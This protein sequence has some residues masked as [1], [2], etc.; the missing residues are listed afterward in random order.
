MANALT[1]LRTKIWAVLDADTE[2]TRLLR[3][4]SKIKWAA[5][6][7]AKLKVEPAM[8]P[9]LTMGP[10][11]MKVPALKDGGHDSRSEWRYRLVFEAFT[12]G[13][14]VSDAEEIVHRVIEVLASEFPFGLGSTTAGYD[15]PHFLHAMEFPEATFDVQPDEKTKNPI[16][17]ATLIAEARYRIT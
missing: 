2:I 14:D 5:G 6:L 12:G 17:L 10:A 13:Q 4:G 3:G 16:W 11:S 1:T 15:R 8:C 9:I 7:R